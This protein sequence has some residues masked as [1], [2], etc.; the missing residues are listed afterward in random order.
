MSTSMLHYDGKQF[1]FEKS[2]VA[3]I[4][5]AIVVKNIKNMQIITYFYVWM[6]EALLMIDYG[7]HC[8]NLSFSNCCISTLNS[9]KQE[10][11][12]VVSSTNQW[13]KLGNN[14]TV[15]KGQTFSSLGALM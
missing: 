6:Q 7:R 10:A 9:A 2:D 12:A 13:L 3:P 1:W 14:G 15:F 11:I 5:S 4:I 8:F